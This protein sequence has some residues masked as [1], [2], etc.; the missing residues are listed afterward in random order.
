MKI[1][2]MNLK[3]SKFYTKSFLYI[4]MVRALTPQMITYTTALSSALDGCCSG[5]GIG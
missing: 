3:T 2:S 1:P 5:M 4:P